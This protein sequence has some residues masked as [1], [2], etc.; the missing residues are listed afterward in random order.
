MHETNPIETPN[1]NEYIIDS[2]HNIPIEDNLE[3]EHKLATDELTL[4]I[5]KDIFKK[6]LEVGNEYNEELS[7]KV[8]S[9]KENWTNIT[10]TITQENISI[11]EK[12][13]SDTRDTK[14]PHFYFSNT[15][16][17]DSESFVGF[18][19]DNNN[20]KEEP[21]K[22]IY[23]TFKDT[24]TGNQYSINL[25]AINK[26]KTTTEFSEM[27][28][29]HIKRREKER[30]EESKAPAGTIPKVGKI[31]DGTIPD[32]DLKRFKNPNSESSWVW[33]IIDKEEMIKQLMTVIYPIVMEK[34]KVEGPAFFKSKSPEIR[35]KI[36][37]ILID[38]NVN[39]QIDPS[40]KELAI[41][42]WIQTKLPLDIFN[43]FIT[44]LMESQ[45]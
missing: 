36:N 13:F 45:Q 26:G 8:Q 33:F 30:E 42:E 37:K 43:E 12:C 38:S 39:F 20:I 10:A 35:E 11:Q 21:D 9:N 27:L 6:Y 7:R 23:Y 2:L 18:V 22:K 31:I 34:V 44:W 32:K 16:K 29:Q 25:G 4:P 5:A 24:V 17:S 3:E 40:F 41:I 15:D 1:P 28:L 19:I 14:N